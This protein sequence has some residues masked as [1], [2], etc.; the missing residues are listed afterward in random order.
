[1]LKADQ[2]LGLWVD[3]FPLGHV[4]QLAPTSF[5]NFDPEPS[6]FQFPSEVLAFGGLACSEFLFETNSTA[7]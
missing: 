1:V 6:G 2:L 5:P 3:V 4:V 7:K